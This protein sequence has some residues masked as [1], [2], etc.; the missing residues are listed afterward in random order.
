MTLTPEQFSKLATKDDLE[1]FKNEV[2][3]NTISKNEF[4]NTMDSVLKKLDNIEHAFVFN[5]AAHDRFEERI[6][7][8][9]KALKL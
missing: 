6:L 3:Q 5:I 7:K 4:H 9:E 8:L 2:R 1:N